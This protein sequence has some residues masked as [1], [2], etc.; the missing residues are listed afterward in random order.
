MDNESLTKY[1]NGIN[2]AWQFLKFYMQRSDWTE[3]AWM[4][5]VDKADELIR[6]H[7]NNK[8][9]ADI[10]IAMIGEME[11]VS[12]VMETWKNSRAS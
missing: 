6:K 9:I 11:R 1:L 7:N 8:M 3:A 10:F 4:E 5:M 2:D 12:G